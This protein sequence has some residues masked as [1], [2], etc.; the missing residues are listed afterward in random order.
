MGIYLIRAA[1]MPG[2]QGSP[3]DDRHICAYRSIIKVPLTNCLDP[4]GFLGIGGIGFLLYTWALLYAMQSCVSL[5]Q[6]DYYR[7]PAHIGHM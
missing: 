2:R 3:Y 5:R 4:E 7:I 6:R 1:H